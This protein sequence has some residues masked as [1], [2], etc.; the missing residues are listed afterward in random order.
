MLLF[1]L[2]ILLRKYQWS[3]QKLYLFFEIASA[4]RDSDFVEEKAFPH[5]S[6][7]LLE[8]PRDGFKGR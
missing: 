2:Q 1:A 5:S 6:S 7:L 3:Y 8:S 4:G